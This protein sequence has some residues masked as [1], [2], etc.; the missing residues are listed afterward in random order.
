M[1]KKSNAKKYRKQIAEFANKIKRYEQDY[2]SELRKKLEELNIKEV[3]LPRNL[4]PVRI[5]IFICK[6]GYL[7]LRFPR[8]SLPDKVDI[9][10]QSTLYVNDIL[11]RY[12]YKAA[13]GVE[14]P[15]VLM[16]KANN[17]KLDVSLPIMVAERSDTKNE[18][19]CLPDFVSLSI[20]TTSDTE[21]PIA[22]VAKDISFF[23]LS[24]NLNINTHDPKNGDYKPEVI[25]TLQRLKN[26]FK[27]L[28]DTGPREE[29][30]Q[31]FL[32]DH[33]I[34]INHFFLKHFPKFSLGSKVT[35]FVFLNRDST[36]EFVE[37][38]KSRDPIFTKNADFTHKVT[39]GKGQLLDWDS[40]IEKYKDNLES[41]YALKGLE[42]RKYTLIIGRKSDW[43]PIFLEKLYSENRLNP[44]IKILTFDDLV[45]NLESLISNLISTRV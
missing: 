43:K 38:E 16:Y 39:H 28:I 33:P 41:K 37:L 22:Q 14:H 1:G 40:V 42:N 7:V 19:V 29:E 26:Q 3:D 23:I 17:G 4:G 35:D 20:Y 11:F 9:E 8:H 2:F 15:Y 31:K 5:K 44:S 34:L 6:D 13:D 10:D 36:Y 32:D 27:M 18:D 21:D 45:E 12:P 30:L 24:R 25:E